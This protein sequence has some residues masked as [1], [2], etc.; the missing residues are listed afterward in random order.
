MSILPLVLQVLTLLSVLIFGIAILD[1]ID[2]L[3]EASSYC[4]LNEGTERKLD[5]ILEQTAPSSS[6][7]TYLNELLN[8]TQSGPIQP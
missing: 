5:L 1:K 3:P 6:P 2:K 7:E 4:E 8:R